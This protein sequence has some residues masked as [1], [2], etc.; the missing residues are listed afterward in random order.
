VMG[1]IAFICPCRLQST[2]M[3]GAYESGEK[4]AVIEEEREANE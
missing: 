1:D 3:P 4:V 2:T